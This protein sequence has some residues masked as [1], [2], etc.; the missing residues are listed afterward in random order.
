VSDRPVRLVLD[1]SAIVSFTEESIHVG[2]VIAEVDDD[3]ASVGLPLLCVVEAATVAADTGRLRL[4]VNHHATVLLADDPASWPAFVAVHK[5]VR[6]F[7]ASAAA[8]L[9]SIRE[10]H[11]LTCQPDLYRGLSDG[12]PVIPF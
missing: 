8:L 10:C 9:A 12:G 5:A 4:L 2:E 7:D 3:R 6:R 1:A 11:V